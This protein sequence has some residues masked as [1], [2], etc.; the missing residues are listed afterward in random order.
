MPGR[1]KSEWKVQMEKLESHLSKKERDARKFRGCMT[2]GKWD[3]AK[4]AAV[5]ESEGFKDKVDAILAYLT[6]KDNKPTSPGKKRGAK[7]QVSQ[8]IPVVNLLSKKTYKDLSA[9]QIGKMIEILTEIQKDRND[10]EIADLKAQRAQIDMRLKE[11][12]VK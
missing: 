9:S 10:Q 7:K 2:D 4:I 12:G 1:K 6:H 11:R 3:K 8:D 5:C